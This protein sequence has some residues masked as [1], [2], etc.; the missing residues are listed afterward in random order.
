MDQSPAGSSSVR[1]RAG[2]DGAT[3]AFGGM[4]GRIDTPE[5][6]LQGMRP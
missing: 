5:G 3:E 4:N 6:T 2:V 1:R